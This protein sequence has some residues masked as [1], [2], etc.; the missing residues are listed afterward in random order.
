MDFNRVKDETGRVYGRLR[1]LEFDHI[2]NHNAYWRCQCSC[3]E[4]CTIR[5]AALRSGVTQ[6]CGCRHNDLCSQ[7]MKTLNDERWHGAT[8]THTPSCKGQ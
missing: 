1:V 7:R 4:T 2:R 8:S 5:G 3:G 6:S